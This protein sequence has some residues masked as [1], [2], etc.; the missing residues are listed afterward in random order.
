[1]HIATLRLCIHSIYTVLRPPHSPR[2]K[3]FLHQD[4]SLRALR[5]QRDNVRDGVAKIEVGQPANI[6]SSHLERAVQITYIHR[7][8]V[9]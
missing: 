3:C 8:H 4:D 1:M 2:N 6:I 5:V 9:I 7:P